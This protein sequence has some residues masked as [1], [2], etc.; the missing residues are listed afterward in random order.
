MLLT[1]TRQ[2]QVLAAGPAMTRYWVWWDNYTLQLYIACKAVVIWLFTGWQH[3]QHAEILSYNLRLSVNKAQGAAVAQMYAEMTRLWSSRKSKR[4][5]TWG[6]GVARFICRRLDASVVRPLTKVTPATVETATL[7]TPEWLVSSTSKSLPSLLPT[8]EIELIVAP[9]TFKALLGR[10]ACELEVCTIT[11]KGPC[12]EPPVLW[13]KEQ[14]HI[15][16]TRVMRIP[17]ALDCM[18]TNKAELPV[19]LEQLMETVTILG[20]LMRLASSWLTCKVQECLPTDSTLQERIWI[21]DP[22]HVLNSLWE[23]T[24]ADSWVFRYFRIV[25]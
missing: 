12:S 7:R 1:G 8:W 4:W 16:Y 11:F 20:W 22:I 5:P 24:W 6:L 2:D 17:V 15:V 23:G 3:P 25:K 14:W 18:S 19:L 9:S 10:L 21:R 13:Y